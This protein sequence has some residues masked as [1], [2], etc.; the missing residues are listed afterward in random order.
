MT[1][2][3]DPSVLPANHPLRLELNDEVHARPTQAVQPPMRVSYIVLLSESTDRAQE[4]QHFASLLRHYDHPAPDSPA[5]YYFAVLPTFAIQYERHTE[6]SR[7]TITAS[8]V[9]EN[10]FQSTAL[11][12]VTDSWLA[13]LR[14]Q[15]LVASHGVVVAAKPGHIDHE[16]ISATYFG[17][18]VLIGSN[19]ADNAAV[20]FTDFRIHSDGFSRFVIVDLGLTPRETGRTLQRILEIDT[21]RMLALLA[22]PIARQLGPMLTQY[23]RELSVVTNVLETADVSDEAMLLD[24]LTHLEAQIESEEAKS[25]FRFTASDA[26]YELVRRRIAEL[27]ETRLPGL[28]TFGEFTE[29]RLAPAMNTC[30]SAATRQESV[31]QHVARANQLL[32]TRVDLSRQRQ[33]QSL[34]ESMNRRAKAQFELQQTVEGLSIAAITYYVAGLIGYIAKGLHAFGMNINYEIVVAVS[35]PIVAGLLMIGLRRIHRTKPRDSSLLD[36]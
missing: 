26:Y 20:A 11:S 25:R 8:G 9:S 3:P 33:S 22:F 7:Y 28:Q 5:T 32:A 29:R 6:F 1:I 31:S 16:S 2:P 34:L 35:I 13:A 14:G 23:E 17:D 30:R 19:V 10:Y 36:D 24:R 21:Y 15:V 27:R 4:W 18:N 12:E